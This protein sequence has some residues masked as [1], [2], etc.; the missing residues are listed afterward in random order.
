MT[1]GPLK[2]P[3]LKTDANLDAICEWV[4]ERMDLDHGE[5]AAADAEYSEPFAPLKAS[6]RAAI[7]AAFDATGKDRWQPLLK[8]LRAGEASPGMMAVVADLIEHGGFTSK[9]DLGSH[10]E[11]FLYHE[12]QMVERVLQTGFPEKKKNPRFRLSTRVTARL[13]D[14]EIGEVQNAVSRRKSE[15][16]RRLSDV[17]WRVATDPTTQD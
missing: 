2:W 5:T 1:A 10:D 4:D 8:V 3:G 11:N 17:R 15:K 9:A 7:L 16:H 14:R 13:F 6:E 12:Y